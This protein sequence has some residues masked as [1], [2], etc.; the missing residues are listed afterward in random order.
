MA[1][2]FDHL[3]GELTEPGQH[4]WLPLDMSGNPV[5]PATIKPPHLGDPA[6]SVMRVD[7]PDA[8][9]QLVSSTGASLVPPLQNNPDRRHEDATPIPH[10][11]LLDPDNVP[12]GGAD[13]T[14]TVNGGNF[15]Q[16]SVIYF[17]GGEEETTYIS[18]S[19]LSTVVKPS[20]A[21]GPISVPVQ[22]KTEAEQSNMVNFTFTEAPEGE[23][24]RR[25]R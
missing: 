5:G 25:R 18:A 15:T 24:R 13:I 11:T 14:L 1:G 8:D 2:Q 4:G 19:Q 22:V 3:L 17:N 10:I 12:V 23:E 7:D 16:D 6:C 20:L 9:E 21:S